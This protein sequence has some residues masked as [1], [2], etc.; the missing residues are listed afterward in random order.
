MNPPSRPRTGASG[1][2]PRGNAATLLETA[3][4]HLL[5]HGRPFSPLIIEKA[6]GSYIQDIT[7]RRILDFSSGQMCATIGHNHPVI[8]AALVEAG[9]T[10][11]HL[12]STKLSPPVIALAAELAEMLPPALQRSMFLNT[13]AESNEAAI[14]LAKLCTG[15]YEVVG[16]AGSWHG[17]TSGA[18]SSTY[19]SGRRG[20][21]PANAGTFP[22]PAPNA[23]RCPIRHC[24]KTCDKTCLR[25]GFELYDSWSTGAG[26]AVIIEPVQ[27]AGG[28]V[29]PPRGYL[30]ELKEKCAERGMLL[31]F[32]EAQTGLGR[33]GSNFAFEDESV[34]PDILTLSKTLGAGVP[35]AAVITSDAINE[36]AREKGYGFYTSH[37]NDP[38]P[39]L[40]GLAV[41]R[42][43]KSEKLA[44]RAREM[45][46]YLGGRLR[47]LQSRYAIIGDVRGRGLLLGVEMVRD[48]ETREPAV[49]SIVK[50]TS[51]CLELGLNV[52]KAGGSNAVW[53]IAPP[54]TITRE[55]VDGA[56]S[57]MD[58]ALRELAC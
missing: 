53:R 33:V 21:G 32:D 39:A 50:I 14:R 8:R 56:I 3:E 58:Q 13:G 12:D 25:A 15:G 5:F 48:R 28:I 35:L 52:N 4:K 29:T 34:T 22:L 19:A 6:E 23:Y 30:A 24:S 36:T 7:G 37:V 27:S 41:I 31:I 42:L 20:Y 47:E 38:L 10:A 54:L 9:T 18:Q 44:A 46:E 55:E 57:I 26:A 45:G 17:M 11:I 16:L 2:A 51:R 43:I 40:V 49:D 1:D